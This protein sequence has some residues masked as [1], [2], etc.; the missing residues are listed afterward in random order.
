MFTGTR[1]RNSFRRSAALN[2]SRNLTAR[3]TADK[4]G[5]NAASTGISFTAGATIAD[6]NNGFGNLKV[7]QAIIVQGSVRNNV[8]AHMTAAAAGSLTVIP[9]QIQSNTAGPLVLVRQW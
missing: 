1:V 9:A 6:S 8:D 5:P 2:M 3:C 4:G 7:G